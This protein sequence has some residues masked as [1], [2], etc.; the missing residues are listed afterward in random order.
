MYDSLFLIFT[1]APMFFFSVIGAIQ[2]EMMMMMMM[3]M[4]PV[5][6]SLLSVEIFPSWFVVC[7]QI[8]GRLTWRKIMSHRRHEQWLI[9]YKESIPINVRS[10]VYAEFAEFP[11]EFL[12][13]CC[14]CLRQGPHVDYVH[15]T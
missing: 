10:N 4:T 8:R 1:V 6:H 9:R 13:F 7:S 2:F 12:S 14:M 3:M 15:H 11:S 5:N